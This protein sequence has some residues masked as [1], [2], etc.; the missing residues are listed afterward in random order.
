MPCVPLFEFLLMSKKSI[1][2]FLLLVTLS[3]IS[4]T[5]YLCNK[6]VLDEAKGKLFTDAQTI[7]YNKVGLLLGTS[8]SLA[9]GHDNPFYAYRIKAAAQLLKTGKIKYIIV[10]GDNSV[11]GYN[12]PE[13]MR[14]DLEKE[15]IDS[16]V[17]YLDYA[18][19]RTFDSMVRLKEI[20]GQD[21]CTIISQA[22]H[23][24]RALYIAKR[25]GITAI[26]FNAQDVNSRF[27]LGTSVRERFARVKVFVDYL[28]G[29]KPRFLG[30]KVLMP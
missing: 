12:E 20:F 1:L 5:V 18:G 24:E 11:V 6:S 26:G 15:G 25:E 19:F 10:S 21:S 27:G 16:S 3:A 13:Q 9:N 4:I 8:K 30:E 22:F 17:I 29:K 2:L 7:P 23:N 14:Q 28:I